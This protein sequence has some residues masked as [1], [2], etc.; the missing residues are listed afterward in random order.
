[1]DTFATG[2]DCAAADFVRGFDSRPAGI[3]ERL[4]LLRPID[5]QPPT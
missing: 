3:I 1:V 4:D 5:C 2:D